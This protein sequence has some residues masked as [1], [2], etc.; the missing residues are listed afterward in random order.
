MPTEPKL[1]EYLSLLDRALGQIP[2]SDRSDIITEIKSHILEARERDPNQEISQILAAIGEPENVANRYLLERG[3][4]PGRP[5]KSPIVKWLTLGFLGTLGILTIAFFALIWRFTPLIKV[6]EKSGRVIILGGLIDVDEKEG[7]V[8]IG[9]THIQHD[10]ESKIFDGSSPIDPAK[11][12]LIRIPFSNGK[13]DVTPSAD[14]QLHWRCKVHGGLNS[15]YVSKE[16][17]V[18]TLGLENT[19]GAKCDIQLPSSIAAKIEGAN[20]TLDLERPQASLEVKLSN[21]KIKLTPDSKK[22]YRYETQVVNGHVEGF[23]SSDDKNAIL[24][25]LAVTNGYIKRD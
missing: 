7:K 22:K 16:K 3:I 23:D 12:D 11:F 1:E 17:K 6:D 5:S 14:G 19:E 20:G 25:K 21:G 2:V 10:G 8:R 15:A 4:K 18:F 9:G 13:M 24:I